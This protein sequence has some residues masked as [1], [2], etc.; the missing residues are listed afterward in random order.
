MTREEEIE[1]RLKEI[2][3]EKKLIDAE[4][5]LRN[6]KSNLTRGRSITV[7]NAFGGTTEISIRGDGDAYLW[8]L[9]QP[10]EVTEL[11][12]QLAGN[13]GCHINI[14]PRQDFASW[15]NWKDTDPLL[16]WQNPDSQPKPYT[17]EQI[18]QA[19]IIGNK[20]PPPEQQPGTNFPK[21]PFEIQNEPLAVEKST[22]KRKSKRTSTPT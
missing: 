1:I 19:C 2:E 5:H 12:H 3:N 7:G 14:Q 15:R 9:L 18:D 4:Q 11:I 10:V 21:K 8:L 16:S 20:L 13:I 22:N 6:Y 17:P